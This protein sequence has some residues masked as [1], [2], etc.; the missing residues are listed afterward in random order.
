MLANRLILRHDNKFDLDS[1]IGQDIFKNFL[2]TLEKLFRV[3]NYL[4]II[5]CSL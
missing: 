3:S 4:K 5:H 1:D 2:E